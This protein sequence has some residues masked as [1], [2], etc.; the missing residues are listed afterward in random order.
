L[1][2]LA[3]TPASVIAAVPLEAFPP[4]HASPATPPVAVQLVALVEFHVSVVAWPALMV[5]GAAERDAVTTG[6]ASTTVTWV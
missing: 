6:T 5:V 1:S 4:A 3:G 2:G